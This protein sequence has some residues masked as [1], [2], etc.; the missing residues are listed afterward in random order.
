MIKKENTVLIVEDDPESVE[1]LKT[2][3]MKRGYKVVGSASNGKDALKIYKQHSPAIVTM[4][5][6]MPQVDGRKCTQD[7]LEYDPHANIVVV[8]VLGQD[9]LNALESLG[10]KAFIKKPIDIEELFNAL[11]NISISIVRDEKEHKVRAVGIAEAVEKELT[12]STLFIDILHHDFINPLG[13]IKNFGELLREEQPS[14]LKPH[15]EAIIRN[16]EKLID[17]VEDASA[18]SRLEDLKEI[19]LEETI[20]AELVKGAL[21]DL[22]QDSASKK[23][24]I[25]FSISPDTT[26]MA[27]PLF[28]RAMENVISNAIKYS[29]LGGTV[30]IKE[31]IMNDTVILS[32][33][34]K[35]PGIDDEHKKSVFQRFERKRKEG[36]KGSGLGLALVK[37]IMDLGE[38]KVWVEDNPDGGCLF[39]LQMKGPSD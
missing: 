13:L 26:V 9:E 8:S 11:I 10:V 33:S 30:N 20:L 37:K 28:E 5:I 17:L 24:R 35:G 14:H 19:E 32:I 15:V 23:I 18:L 16:A 3:F 6:M 29:P 38:G 27:N 25:D 1:L 31:E 36:V 21:E 2:L 4:D 39:K 34:D 7:I 12:S 22:Q